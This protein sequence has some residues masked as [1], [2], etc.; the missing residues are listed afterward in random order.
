MQKQI[1]ANKFND[2]TYARNAVKVLDK[3]ENAKG[4]ADQAGK[5]GNGATAALGA[6]T[7]GSAWAKAIEQN[8][9]AS[10]DKV[11][12]S[13][14]SFLGGLAGGWAGG[15]VGF[16]AGVLFGVLTGGVG[17][18]PLVGA[19]AVG[20]LGG[21]GGSKLGEWGWEGFRD[22]LDQNRDGKFHIPKDPLVLDLDGD[23]IET[24]QTNGYQGAMFD[25]DKDGIQVATG[26]VA[27]DDG[28]LVIDK[29]GDGLINNGGELFGDN[30]VLKDGTLATTGYAALADYDSN[31]DKVIDSK[32]AEFADLSVW[33]DL[34]QDGTSQSNE[35]FTLA[36]LNIQ[37]LD[38][39]HQNVDKHLGNGK[40][41]TK[42][43]CLKTLL[44]A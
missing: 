9:Q 22:W 7:M 37:S 35:W 25:H 24:V 38:L 32:D 13:S 16:G 43:A 42:N 27:P 8:D 29:N 14:S 41:N 4:L 28:L 40:D 31:G 26:W 17:W 33:R 12:E 1:N 3:A 15:H 6:L 5:F 19:A 21:W 18:L 39:E 44:V 34:N 23:G 36:Q 11:G 30:Q 20:A 10:W 2:A